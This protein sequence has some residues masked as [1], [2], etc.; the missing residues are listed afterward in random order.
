[1]GAILSGEKRPE[2]FLSL[3]ENNDGEDETK[4]NFVT[5]RPAR[6]LPLFNN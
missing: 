3:M 4:P 5:N 6:Y 2:A 1:L